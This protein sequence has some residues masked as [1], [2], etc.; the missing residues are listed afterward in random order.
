MRILRL[1]ARV[2]ALDGT[3]PAAVTQ[4]DDAQ[5]AAT[6]R[7]A[8]AAS[9]VLAHNDRGLLPLDRSALTRVA[10][11]G[12]NAAAARTMGGG[13]A[14]VFPPYAVSPLDGLRAA[15]EGVAS[16]EHRPGVLT[17]DRIEVARQPWVRRPDG[18][19]PGVEVRFLGPDGSLVGSE[20]RPG[21]AFTWLGAFGDGLAVAEVARVEVHAV[22][23][24]TE[25][26]T[27]AIGVSGVGRYRLSVGGDVVFDGALEVA[28]GTDVVEALMVPPQAVHAVALEHG[29]E[30]AVVLEHEVGSA[31]SDGGPAAAFQLNLR[32]PHGTDDD[33]IE[34]A[35]AWRATRTSRS[36]S[37]GRPRRS[38]ARASTARRSR[39]PA[40]RTSSSGASPRRTRGRSSSSTPAPRCCCRGPMT[41]PRC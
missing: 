2:G 26:G 40:A 8:A 14:T 30:V 25:P 27:Y 17:S 3:T 20:H 11:I 6:L 15:L 9:F 34:R 21:C 24:A 38:R 4:P 41:W 31:G 18:G 10:V 19:G 1:A 29:E 37:S 28:P 13:S 16:V 33:E 22:V 36:S 12:A 32:P 23:R 5:V 35:V 7:R 39:C